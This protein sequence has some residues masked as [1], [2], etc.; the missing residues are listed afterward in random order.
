MKA[1]KARQFKVQPAQAALWLTAAFLVSI[2][3]LHVVE[4]EF[5]PRWRAVSEYSLGR[6]GW[7][8]NLAFLAMGVG[9]IALGVALR[10]F[11]DSRIARLGGLLLAVGRVLHPLRLLSYRLLA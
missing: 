10:Q 11:L 4:P 3:V 9:S 7:L 1:P 6:Y 8:M 5:S 2:V